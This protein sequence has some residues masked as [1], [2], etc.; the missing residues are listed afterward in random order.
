MIGARKAEVRIVGRGE[1]TVNPTLPSSQIS[2]DDALAPASVD[3]LFDD[4]YLRLKAMA[5]RQIAHGRAEKYARHHRAGA[6]TA[7]AHQLPS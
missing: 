2:S 1:Q 7:L 3:T 5:R 6:R 4:V